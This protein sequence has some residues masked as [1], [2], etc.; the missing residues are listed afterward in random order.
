MMQNRRGSWMVLLGVLLGVAILI[1]GAVAAFGAPGEAGPVYLGLSAEGVY[2]CENVI[3]VDYLMER[4]DGTT[5]VP[6]N[7][8]GR[9][10]VQVRTPNGVWVTLRSVP[11]GEGRRM[12]QDGRTAALGFTFDLARVIRTDGSVIASSGKPE[13]QRCPNP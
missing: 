5:W 12:V 7:D 11:M 6:M 8:D 3:M 13:V 4:L 9:V 10:G 1:S 2:V